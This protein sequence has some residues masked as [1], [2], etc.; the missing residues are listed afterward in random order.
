MLDLIGAIAL[1]ASAALA[2][3]T[4]TLAVAATSNGRLQVAAGLSAWFLA[5][6]VLGATYALH[7]ERD[8]GTP[9]LGAAVFLPV[10]GLALAF[11]IIPRLRVVPYRIPLPVL[12]GVNV[13]RVFGVVF[14]LLYAAGRLP[15]PFAPTA[16]WGDP[17][18]PDRRARRLG[19]PQG[20][21]PRA[22][23]G[24][25]HARAGRPDHGDRP[26]RRLI[27][28]PLAGLHGGAERCDHGDP[29]V[30]ADPVL[31]GAPVHPHSSGRVPSPDAAV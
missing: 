8:Y 9:A 10:I 22:G 12:I 7:Y 1:T 16:R 5:V 25:E 6:V 2:I 13:L 29:A 17:C 24:L 11:L 18:R 3:A 23:P 30:G 19:R 31:P 27:S 15:A 21:E 20:R 14:V 26:W 28:G 4:L